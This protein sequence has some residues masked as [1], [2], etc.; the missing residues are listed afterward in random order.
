MAKPGLTSNTKFRRARHELSV[1][2]PHL[3][4]YLECL[5]A[6]GYESG[7]AV[8]GDAIDIELAAQW[9][10][11]PGELFKA[12]L[13]AGG[14]G[15]VGFIEPAEDGQDRYQIRNL[16]K[17]APGYVSDRRD[18]ERELQKERHCAHCTKSFHSTESHAKFCSTACRVAHHRVTH[19]N[20]RV[21]NSN[22]DVTGANEPP[23][24][25]HP[26]PSLNTN[27][28]AAQ[29]SAAVDKPPT[30]ATRPQQRV[31]REDTPPP[32]DDTSVVLTFPCVPGRR[33]EGNTWEL[34]QSL[35]DEWA[36]TYPAIDVLQI[37]R[38]ALEWCRS[39][40]KEVKTAKSMRAWISGVWLS[41][42]QN[43]GGRTFNGTNGHH[44][45]TAATRF[46][47]TDG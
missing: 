45:P 2:V 37:C 1:P 27:T 20:E 4:G 11:E 34:R 14:P 44:Q 43:R 6:V 26:T 3:I 22:A 7:C 41:K 18:K 32:P 13:N 24:P 38:N 8:I 9:P 12:L 30:P 31:R 29:A 19:G 46:R 47:H 40:P 25:P 42:E 17:H 23:I 28:P 10:G 33:S 36:T 15:R 35:I 21:R 5:W 16:F 39:H